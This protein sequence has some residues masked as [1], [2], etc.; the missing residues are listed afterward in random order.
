[1]LALSILFAKIAPKTSN[2]TTIVAVIVAVAGF[3]L[4]I[5]VANRFLR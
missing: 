2:A 4:L 3:A 5:Y 1:L